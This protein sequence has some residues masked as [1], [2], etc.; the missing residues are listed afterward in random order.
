M[1]KIYYI[2]GFIGTHFEIAEKH[3]EFLKYSCSEYTKELC[4]I[5]QSNLWNGPPCERVPKPYPNYAADKCTYSSV[6]DTPTSDRHVDDFQPRKN[7]QKLF[8]AGKLSTD[9][10]L[11][12]FSKKFILPCKAC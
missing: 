9:S 11:D 2:E 3:A 10:E 6:C 4:G 1:K 12:G 7:A 5:Y 8:T